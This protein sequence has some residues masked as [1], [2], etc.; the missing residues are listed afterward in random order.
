MKIVIINTHSI[1]NSGDAGIVL[2]QIEFLRKASPQSEIS[3]TSRTPELDR[4]F[5]QPMGIVVFPPLIPAPSI[6][7][8]TGMKIRKCLGNLLDWRQKIQLVKKIK[9]CDLVISSGG[10]YFYS[11]RRFLPGPMFFQNF[12]HLKLAIHFRKPVVLFPQSI[13]PFYNRVAPFFLKKVLSGDMVKRIFCREE[14]SLKILRDLLAGKNKK[15]DVCPDMVFCL[16]GKGAWP[17]TAGQLNLPHPVVAM[18]VRFWN[19]PESVSKKERQTHKTAY[20]NAFREVAEKIYRDLGGSVV[21]FPQVRGP[22]PIEDDRSVSWQL[23]ASLGNRIQKNHLQFV[24]VPGQSSPLQILKIVSQVDLV[25]ATR[26]HSALFAMIAG[27]P[28]ITVSYQPKSQGIMDL[29]GLARLNLEISAV[30]SGKIFLLV[31]EVLKN[32]ARIQMHLKEKV[33][34]LKVKIETKLLEVIR[35][36]DIRKE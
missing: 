13:G 24:D 5:Y 32:H 12:L 1:L 29:L 26:F 3:L 36:I 25:I 21:I 23:F 20:L 28:A 27:V 8:S 16:S 9:Q 33:A 22:G 19:F 35:Q 15:A 14:K 6:Y 10:G 11:N 2:A 31:E 30:D 18:T 34:E 17:G 4:K 7:G